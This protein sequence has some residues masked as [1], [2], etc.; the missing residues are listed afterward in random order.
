MRAIAYPLIFLLCLVLFSTSA[1]AAEAG[2]GSTAAAPSAAQ[3]QNAP[4]AFFSET[5]H[6]FSTVVSGKPVDHTFTVKNNGTAPL[7]IAKIK[8]G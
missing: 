3:P 8:T 2:K 1:V 5:A 7:E 6:T 4:R